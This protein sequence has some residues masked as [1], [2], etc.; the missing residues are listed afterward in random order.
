MKIE[1]EPEAIMPLLAVLA[2]MM[3]VCIIMLIL[4]TINYFFPFLQ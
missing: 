3:I 4:T 1:I 2:F